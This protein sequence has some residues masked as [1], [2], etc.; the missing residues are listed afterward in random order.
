MA[1]LWDIKVSIDGHP[2]WVYSADG[3]F[4]YPKEVDAVVLPPGERFQAMIKLDKPAGDY[5]IRAATFVT[6]QFLT[7]YGVLSYGKTSTT[8]TV[9]PPAKDDSIGYGGNTL[10]GK[11]ELA[12]MTLQAYP[13][14]VKPPQT[15]NVTLKFRLHRNNTNTWIMN[16]DPFHAHL[17]E[18][19]PLLINPSVASSYDP[20]LVPKYPVGSIVDIVLIS[21]KGNPPHPIH[22]HGV[23]AWIIGQGRADFTWNTVAQA[24]A[25][26]PEF[27]N[28]NNPPYRDGFHTL[29]SIPEPTFTVFRFT[30]TEPGAIFMHCHINLHAFG[31]MGVTL[32]EGMD[33]PL[34]IPQYYLDWNEAQ[35]NVVRRSVKN[36][37]PEAQRRRLA[38]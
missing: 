16:K 11:R 23:K 35:K 22:K 32:M 25:A 29:D 38:A 26:R 20:D 1:H 31:G 36:R 12:P 18:G 17:E 10:P 15:A 28:L 33:A 21:E 4:H 3:Q 9:V 34:T 5:A 19:D 8:G 2:M 14:T 6:P 27:F 30:V 24:I 13:N 37:S 7:G